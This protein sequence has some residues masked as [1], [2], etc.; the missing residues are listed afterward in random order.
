MFKKI[1]TTS[2]S[3]KSAGGCG[4]I[5][6]GIIWTL[7]SSLF[8][9]FGIK[10][11]YDGIGRSQ[12]SEVSCEVTEFKIPGNK[13]NLDPPFQP[14]VKYRYNWEGSTRHGDKLRPNKD[15]EEKFEKLGEIFEQ[16]RNGKLKTCYVN[17]ENPDE[18]ALVI[19][20][21]DTLNGLI[22]TL[23]GA[24]FMAIGFGLITLG[25]REK[26][27][28][29]L[30]LSSQTNTSDDTPAIILIPFFSVFAL[31]GLGILFFVVVPAAI[32]YSAAK[33]WQETPAKVIWSKLRSHSS[34]DGTTYSV[35]IF[36]RYAFND[37]VYR[38]NTGSYTRSSSS[39]RASK[40]K[41]IKAH[42]R[43]AKI[44]CYV[45]PE[46]PWQA[47]RK[48]DLGWSALFALFPLPFIAIGIGGLWW[49]LR[50]HKKNTPTQN[51]YLTGSNKSGDSSFQGHKKYTQPEIEFTPR[52][53][54]VKAL[55]GILFFAA[56]WCGITSI[57]V[58]IAVKSW[59]R[60]NPEWFLTIFITP[61]VI[62]G[63][64]SVIY[65]LYSF[66]RIFS[67]APTIKLKP[68]AISMDGSAEVSWNVSSGMGSI[69]HFSIYLI[70][71]EEATYQQ[72]TD[73]KTAEETFYEE[74][75]IDTH[76]PRI[77]SRGT[78]H[79]ELSTAATAIMPSWKGKH[80]RIRW[81]LIVIGKISLWPDIADTYEIEIQPIDTT[82]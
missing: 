63:I 70:G 59:L 48:R 32:K 56:F 24:G 79:L 23:I 35:D 66:L 39:G 40:E 75:I 29:T 7:F 55:L 47:I 8:F 62:I 67:P 73:T 78:A 50:K 38:S 31:A 34:D 11:I 30:A 41:I 42:P 52:A 37:R 22:P 69:R 3:K 27:N 71:E 60:D 64:G 36:Y 57:F 19:N 49:M 6:F 14:K 26:K 77:I 51:P 28:K 65:S 46:K 5:G 13:P 1:S 44:V 54:R 12:W 58:V 80:N 9:L 72:G 61:F 33:G 17:P 43:G 25:R 76:D 53:K 45:N 20:N 81:S 10:S 16:Y 4:L 15:G 2:K 18:S 68:S 21:S 74:A 82:L